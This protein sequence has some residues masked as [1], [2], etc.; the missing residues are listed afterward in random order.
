MKSNPPS[1]CADSFSGFGLEN[2]QQ[3]NQEVREATQRLEKEVIP[4]Y[5]TKLDNNFASGL[6]QF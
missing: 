3:H 5:A 6:F 4:A 1:L 2:K